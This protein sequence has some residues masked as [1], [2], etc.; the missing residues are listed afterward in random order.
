MEEIQ[1]KNRKAKNP[2][3]DTETV[4]VSAVT[5]KAK[6]AKSSTAA[7]YTKTSATKK[8]TKSPKI[9]TT[10]TEK[11]K[12]PKKQTNISKTKVTKKEA[13][14]PKTKATKK[15]TDTSEKKE[16]KKETKVLKTNTNKK[17]E[18]IKKSEKNK[19]SGEPKLTIIH[20][21]EE[22]PKKE[23][24]SKKQKDKNKNKKEKSKQNKEEKINQNKKEKSKNKN[25]KTNK[26]GY[27]DIS[28][29]TIICTI[30]II[31]LLALNIKLGIKAYNIIV[32]KESTNYNTKFDNDESVTQEVGNVLSNSNELVTKMREKITF[33]P[34]VIASLYNTETFSTTT[35]PNDLIL[36][37][38]WAK[39]KEENKL[40]SINENNEAIEALEKI[41]MEESIK[42]I[43]GPQIKYKDETF[44][45]TDI[46]TFS[47]YCINKG[48]IIYDNGLYTN[49]ATDNIDEQISPI[50][51]QEMQK[52]VK[53]SDKIIVYVK[54]AYMDTDGQRYIVY[55]DFNEEKF[56]EQ[57][58]EITQEELF[59]EN[60]FNPYT[61]EG[62]VSIETN[63]SLNSIREQLDTYKYTF[64]LDNETGEYYLSKFSKALS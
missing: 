51:Y 19:A 6:S 16:T 22:T 41:A 26:K 42:N 58:L 30:I 9:N 57:L 63:N 38:G 5:E 47:S 15:E 43:F 13:D 25:N 37:L 39:V 48:T 7:K 21:K 4:K 11:G 17:N 59:Q 29:G 61:G 56:E 27:I 18:I 62:T 31:G 34:N 45:N 52:V 32:N 64:S 50:I 28:I 23:E 49:I 46:N 35:I 1:K 20:E 40:K 10:K 12:S 44:N 55:K 54:V 8:E 53:Y 3:K 24:I 60:L 14:T 33:A 36:R 2:K